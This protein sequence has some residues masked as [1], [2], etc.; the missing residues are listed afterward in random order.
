MIFRQTHNI[1][2]P[3]IGDLGSIIRT[4]HAKLLKASPKIVLD[5]IVSL[6]LKELEE[7]LKEAKSE[8]VSMYNVSK[9][10]TLSWGRGCLQHFHYKH[11]K[12]ELTYK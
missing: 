1:V 5:K 7:Q 4:V 10:S 8:A 9:L 3:C 2:M 12:G 6:E 11:R